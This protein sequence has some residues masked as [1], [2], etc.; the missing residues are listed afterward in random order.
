MRNVKQGAG[1]SNNHSISAKLLDSF[2]QHWLHGREVRQPDV[3][4]FDAAQ[5]QGLLGLQRAKRRVELLRCSD[6]ID[7]KTCS[8]T[9]PSR[10]LGTVS[11]AHRH[12]PD[13]H[14]RYA[15]QFR[16]TQDMVV[17]FSG[18]SH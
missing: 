5:A 16:R 17:E 2:I 1:R 7:V 15:L 13:I 10:K 11:P 8:V 18:L 3:P 6:H 12:V 4:S 9:L 14:K